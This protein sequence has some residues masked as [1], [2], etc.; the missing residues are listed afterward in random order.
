MT[1]I[2]SSSLF[3]RAHHVK[4][5]EKSSNEFTSLTFFDDIIPHVV[6]EKFDHVLLPKHLC[7]CLG[8]DW[9]RRR[10]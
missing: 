10:T 9:L 2:T 3:P 8:N 4:R 6:T 7:S 5:K 1:L